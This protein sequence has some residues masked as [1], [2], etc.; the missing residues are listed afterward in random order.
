[1]I[2]GANQPS[3]DQDGN[4]IDNELEE[5]KEEDGECGLG[6]SD[7]ANMTTF[8]ENLVKSLDLIVH[9]LFTYLTK[10]TSRPMGIGGDL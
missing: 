5:I 7:S 3:I 1:M 4:I 8:H 9:Q 10:G 2:D 6:L